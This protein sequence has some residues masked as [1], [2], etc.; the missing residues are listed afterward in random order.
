[1]S[2][3]TTPTTLPTNSEA[4]TKLIN[5]IKYMLGEGIIDLEL[6]PEHYDLAVN[7][8][9][10]RYRQRSSNAVEESYLFMSLYPDQN[11][12]YLPEEVIEIRALFRR[13]VTAG[14]LGTG[15]ID[16]F[17]IA[18]TNAY[19]LNLGASGIASLATY[20]FY[21]Q[22]QEHLGRMFGRDINFSWDTVRKK[23]TVMRKP[24]AVEQ[25][26][27]WVY[28][29]KP[30]FVILSDTYA[31]N[32][33]REYAVARAKYIIGEARS[34]FSSIPGPQ[35]G[36][37]LNGN[38]MKNEAKETMEKLDEELKL[39]TEQSMGYGFVIG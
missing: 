37:Q 6:D 13:G 20:D 4:R 25:I 1:M 15:L 9:F 12:Y 24:A 11:E 23:L 22:Y 28:N 14:N 10:D 31:K 7:L 17:N 38:D 32:W 8:A 19:L 2:T 26:L 39:Q 36:T 33:I 21:A 35:G 18:Y 5:E 30:D 27:L 34:K 29:Y 16:P 3:S